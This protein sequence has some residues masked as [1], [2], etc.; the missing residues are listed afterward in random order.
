MKT[1]FIGYLIKRLITGL[2]LLL[3]YVSMLFFA[4]QMIL[5]G[6][7]VS[8]AVLGLTR[9]QAMELRQ[10]L[11]LD[12]PI[13]QR[14][15]NWMSNIL[16]GDLGP[17]YSVFGSAPPV[18]EIIS[19][20]L[21]VT[22]LIFGLGTGIAFLAGMWLGKWSAF[23]GPGCLSSGLTFF[24]VALYTAF[25]PWLSFLLI[26]FLATRLNIPIS[27]GLR[28]RVG[29]SS[30][31]SVEIMILM[32]ASFVVVLSIWLGLNWIL[33]RTRRRSIPL[34]L[35]LLLLIAGWILSWVILDIQD[36]ALIIL[37]S[38]ILPIIAYALLSFG[39]VMLIMRTSMNET[40]HEDY[41]LT[42]RAKGLPAHLVRD[43]HAAR[44]A[45]LP[46]VS[47]LIISLPFLFSGM[48]MIERV[49]SVDGIGTTLFF[50]LGDQNIPLALGILIAIGVLAILAHLVLD[51]VQFL[52]DPRLRTG[53]AQ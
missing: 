1:G 8:H 40:L 43:R 24:S 45:L 52:L 16:R 49:L 23:R 26:Y 22:I 27:L 37:R 2:V 31:R 5:P 15:L 20:T 19:R 9:Q 33:V 17:S 6:D 34:L 42:A 7:Y 10:Q 44:T 41:V 36:Q 50:S 39:E 12:L 47:R 13:L 3:V 21:P 11:G 46:V 28:L 29:E 30:V 35:F 32:I 25:P 14:Y 4:I 38:I 18:A 53:P 51:V 48:V